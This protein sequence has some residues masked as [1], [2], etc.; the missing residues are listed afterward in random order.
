MSELMT[1]SDMRQD[2]EKFDHVVVEMSG[3]AEP[4]SVRNIFQEAMLYDMP[5]MD[6]VQLDTLVT[7]VDC[8][9]YLDYLKSKRLADVDESPELYYRN[10]EE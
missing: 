5:L 9:T 3:V 4:R 10:E 6:R 7:V 1:L 2:D 8:S